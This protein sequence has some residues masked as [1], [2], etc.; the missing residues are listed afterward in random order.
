[1]SAPVVNIAAYRFVALPNAAERQAPF[2]QR[3]RE[4]GLLGT[5]LLTPE[6]I[7]LFLAGSRSGI[8]AFLDWLR[9]DPCFTAI[10]VKESLSPSQPF[11]RLRIKVR[12]EII[13]M[14]LPQIRPG[15]GRAPAVTP[16]DLKRWLDHGHD[17]AGRPVVLL[18][19]RNAFEVA[20]GTFDHARH[21]GLE[22]FTEFPAAVAA[23][24]D[25]LAG[26][27]VVTFCTGGIR[28]EKAAIF[29]AQAGIE[30]VY[31]LDGGILGYFEQVGG[32]HYHGAC[33]VFDERIAVDPALA[34]VAMSRPTAANLD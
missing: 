2:E 25:E 4:L 6:G 3:C 33:F 5:V 1:M 28:C 30:H 23:R 22:K 12:A 13:T 24:R 26:S 34:P 27:T 32:A 14:R 7:N 15:E 10:E 16:G 18:D 20:A 8:D 11:H 19:T 31:Q 9:A 21:Y 17:D 29:M